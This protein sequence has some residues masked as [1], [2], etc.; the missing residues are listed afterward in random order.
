VQQT[1]SREDEQLCSS[2]RVVYSPDEPCLPHHL[3]RRSRRPPTPPCTTQLVPQIPVAYLQP[4]TN[5]ATSR[6][7]TPALSAATSPKTASR[8]V[9]STQTAPRT[10]KTITQAANDTNRQ[11]TVQ[12][13]ALH[14]DVQTHSGERI[15]CSTDE[16]Y[17]PHGPQTQ[18]IRP[19]TPPIPPQLVSLS[20]V[21]HPEPPST[22]ATSY[23]TTPVPLVPPPS[24]RDPGLPERWNT[25]PKPLEHSRNAFQPPNSPQLARKRAVSLPTKALD[26]EHQQLRGNDVATTVPLPRPPRSP[27]QLRKCSTP[28]VSPQLSHRNVVSSNP[29]HSA[30][31]GVPEPT[32]AAVLR[33]PSPV[34]TP[35]SPVSPCSTTPVRFDWAE[36]AASIP[37]VPSSYTRDLSSLQTRCLQPFRTLRRRTRRRRAPPHFLSQS[38]KSSYPALPLVP[39]SQVQ[40]FITRRHPSG[41]GPGK[42]IITIPFGTTSAPTPGLKLDWDQDPRLANLG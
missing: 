37:I 13:T 24:E 23:S 41:I 18:P 35:P 21:P 16:P 8:A 15:V 19:P 27:T 32:A 14:E 4:P 17:G 38:R 30:A 1:D 36:D 42:P 2:N 12:K 11:S 20:P 33:P 39:Q 26:D 28:P 10:L 5:V 40:F 22:A 3:Q 6:P 9:F 7:P 29:A 34:L 25:P 31:P